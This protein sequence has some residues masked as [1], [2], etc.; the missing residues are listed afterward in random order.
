MVDLHD[1]N[2]CG[3]LEYDDDDV[4]DFWI[5]HACDACNKWYC[6]LG[7]PSVLMCAHQI[8]CP[9]YCLHVNSM[10]D[11][12]YLHVHDCVKTSILSTKFYAYYSCKGIRLNITF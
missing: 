4:F 10:H 3:V 2:T 11:T 12:L 5:Y 6:C 1:C 8:I 7:L 9:R